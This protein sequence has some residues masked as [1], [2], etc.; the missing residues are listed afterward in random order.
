MNASTPEKVASVQQLLA[1]R[2]GIECPGPSGNV[3]RLRLINLERHVLAGGLPA[4][5]R[6]IAL[7]G[8]VG[9][10]RVL[11]ADDSQISEEGLEVRGYLDGL[12]RQVIV[13]P[14]LH[15]TVRIPHAAALELGADVVGQL[16]A[17]VSDDV[18]VE[19][20]ALLPPVDYRWA[21]A[22]AMG[23]EDRDGDGNPLWGR[24]ALTRFATFREERAGASDR[25]E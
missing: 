16:P 7:E 24:E 1:Q 23:E 4:R 22:V 14:S 18:D 10:A 5:L 21:V 13:E 17:G 3:Y 19:K 12:V 15:G 6:A 2:K 11:A 9:I 20:V 25:T 8:A